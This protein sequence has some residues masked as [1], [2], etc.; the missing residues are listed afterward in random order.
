MDNT[1]CTEFMKFLVKFSSFPFNFFTHFLQ[2]FHQNK[3][4]TVFLLLTQTKT[5]KH[6][7]DQHQPEHKHAIVFAKGM[8][9]QPEYAHYE[10][11]LYSYSSAM[12]S[13]NNKPV[14]NKKDNFKEIV[15]FT[16]RFVPASQ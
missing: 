10:Q 9:M 3:F 2:L 8:F 12:F 1:Q 13:A 16:K 11:D 5:S 4:E 14:E 7:I 15:A 6:S